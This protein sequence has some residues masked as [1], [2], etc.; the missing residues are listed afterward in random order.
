MAGSA[1][2]RPS[3]R[4]QQQADLLQLAR[5]NRPVGIWLLLWP[6]LWALWLAAGGMPSARLLLVFVLGTV[7]M[8]SAGC[9]INDLLD[10]NIDPHVRRT[11]DR[12]LAARR[13][14]PYTAV[15]LALLLLAV[16]LALALLLNAVALRLAFVGAALTVTYPLFKR[17][18]PVP[19][20]YLGL[21]F[22]WSVPMAFAA[23]LGFVPR[24]GWVLLLATVLWAGV[25][26]TFYAMAD[27]ADDQRIGVRSSAISFGDLD[28]LM[29]G[30]MQLMMLLALLLVGRSLALGAPYYAALAIGAALFALH[31]R[32]ARTRERGDCLRAFQRSHWFGVVVLAGIVL[33]HGAGRLIR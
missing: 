19:Q 14:S 33:E 29:I 17:F 20:L 31:L 8:R 27:R 6:A 5:L 25:Y 12:P 7:V 10:R 15:A 2:Q 9:I 3:R 28:L 24:A 4:R 21:C 11:R 23:T 26:D 32:V 16:A 22:G 13:V 18:F 1:E 30:S